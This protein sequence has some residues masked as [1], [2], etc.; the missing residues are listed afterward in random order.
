MNRERKSGFN[1]A[2]EGSGMPDNAMKRSLWQLL[3]RLLPTFTFA[4]IRSTHRNEKLLTKPAGE[5]HFYRLETQ[6][7]NGAW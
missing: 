2:R 3:I 5:W 1:A 7:G 6:C 4:P